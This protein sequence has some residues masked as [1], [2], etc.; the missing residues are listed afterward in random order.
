ALGGDPGA[1]L[2]RL[3]AAVKNGLRATGALEGDADLKSLRDD[4]RWAA[5]L[6]GSRANEAAYL[7]DANAELAQIHHDDQADRRGG[8]SAIN[9]AEV[10]PRDVARRKRVDEILA[11][12]GA[13]V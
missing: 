2:A 7:K 6:A 10:T 12:G 1:A 8:W 3:E 13:K 5:V 4:P 11:A 9:W